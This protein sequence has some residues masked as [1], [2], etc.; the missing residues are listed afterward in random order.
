DIGGAC[1]GLLNCFV[2]ANALFSD[3]AVNCIAIASADMHSRLL[4]PGKVPGE[5]GGLFGD[6]ASAF[7]LRRTGDKED[8]PLYCVRASIGSCSGTFSTVLR[9]RP[10]ANN[11]IVLDFEG[12]ALARAALERIERIVSDLE[13]TLGVS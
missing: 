5:F 1:V 8:P 6:G 10:D 11:S 7:V 2:A 12:Q 3:R 4:G 13:R 9:V